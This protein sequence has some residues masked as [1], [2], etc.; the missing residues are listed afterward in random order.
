MGAGKAAAT[1]Q[2][3]PLNLHDPR[4]P[5]I[6]SQWRCVGARIQTTLALNHGLP[7][8]QPTGRAYPLNHCAREGCEVCYVYVGIG[9]N[10]VR[11]VRLGKYS[12]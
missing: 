9:N 11:Q 6:L 1:I 8:Y 10:A 4:Q 5:L 7:T 2:P 3:Q 12:R